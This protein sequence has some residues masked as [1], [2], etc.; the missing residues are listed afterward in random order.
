MQCGACGASSPDGKRF[1]GE[2][3]SALQMACSSCGSPIE[4]NKRFC[5]DCGTANVAVSGATVVGD[6]AS[7][8]AGG[9]ETR[10][11]DVVAQLAGSAP[12]AERRLC[13]VL[14]VDL[15]G[16]T[17][18]S[19]VRDAEDVREL[20]SSY[21]EVASTIVGRY[22]GTIEKFIGDAV[23]A[24]W[25]SPV[26][27]EEDSERAVRAALDLVDAVGELGTRTGVVGLAARAG[28]LTG[29]VAV[30]I[31]ATNEGMVA[32]DAVN[33][34]A[35]IQ[36]AAS[37]GSVWVDTATQRL[38]ADAISYVDEG[39]HALKGKVD[40][41]RLWR[42]QRVVSSVGGVQRVD[43]L[44]APLTGRGAEV[45]S[46]RELFHASIERRQPRLV[47]VS[48]PAGVGKSRLGWEF[49]KYVDGLV[50]TVWWHRGRC[51]AY[52]DG[53][54][55]WALAEVV[56]QRFGIAE[57]DSPAVA[58]DKLRH[59]LLD[60]VGD[61]GD[62]EFIGLRLGR[63]LGVKVDG[64][65]LDASLTREDLFAG[66]RRF[67][68]QL[69]GEEPVV[70]LIEDAHRAAPELLDFLDHLID[71]ARDL[72]IFVLVFARPDID[73]RRPGFGSGRNRVSITLDPLDATSMDQ[74]VDALIQG[75]APES[76]SIIV[77]RAQGIPLYAVES[78]RALIDRDIVQP[79]DGQYRLVGDIGELGVPN[80]LHALLAARLDALDPIARRVVADAAVL[81]ASFP[82][83]AVT[84]VSG[85]DPDT[86]ESVLALLLR[87]EVLEISAD[88]LSPER[89]SYRFTQEILRQV[90]YDTLS[91]R[92][93]KSRHLAVASHLRATF[94]NDGEEVIDA[95]ARH[96]LDALSEVPDDSDREELTDTAIATLVRAA[97]RSLRT[98]SPGQAVSSF[99]DAA[100]LLATRPDPGPVEAAALWLRA[101]QGAAL[102]NDIDRVVGL[103]ERAGAIYAERND[104]RGQARAKTQIGS[105]KR[106]RGQLAEGRE[107]L[108]E[109]LQVLE[110]DPDLDT[111]DALEGLATVAVFSGSDD[112]DVLTSRALELGHT[113]DVD[114]GRYA[115]LLGLRG[116]YFLDTAG[117]RRL[118][119]MYQRE[120]GRLALAYGDRTV[121]AIAYLNLCN[122]LNIDRPG[123]AIEPARQAIE[124]LSELGDRYWIA[125]VIGNMALA[126]IAVGDW[127]GADDTLFHLRHVD[128][129][130]DDPAVIMARALL[131]G[132]RGDA[133]TAAVVLERQ[134]AI[135]E[136]DDPAI[137]ASL[138]SSRA[139]AAAARGDRPDTLRH[140]LES[141]DASQ[142][143][144]IFAGDDGR[145]TWP[146][147]ARTAHE[148]EQFDV[149]VSLVEMCERLPIG[150]TA[151][152]QRA[153]ATLIRARLA[154]VGHEPDADADT[155]FEA[156][157]AQLRDDSTPYHLAHGLLD[158]AE[159]LTARGALPG[160]L[161]GELVDEARTIADA[162][163]CRPLV[164]RAAQIFG[165]H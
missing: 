90:A 70:I 24:V 128:L 59:G 74:L 34:A 85:L 30:T 71:W 125:G 79:V 130:E 60:H 163:G 23:M 116:H 101:V 131:S 164:E 104:L 127:N 54:V 7:G 91:R 17:S 36:S 95:V 28:V 84:A 40:P 12:V 43:G 123:E 159:H 6:V 137:I 133:D 142:I 110:A 80:S 118:A 134:A 67:F 18:V 113:L 155:L 48:G 75:A 126:Q 102:L 33:T 61:D 73:D 132:L 27:T 47:L 32:G 63:L 55:Y 31:G 44:E 56:R 107:I 115:N 39:D 148:L 81:G 109:A 119:A 11:V 2:C 93:R 150:E 92:D 98:G 138:A 10:S 86:V 78:I 156:A 129:V 1:C 58:A 83:E 35:R 22:G 87:R 162:L 147:A 13:S 145:W 94:S 158:H 66:W 160:E 124:I 117:Q 100:R 53:L 45:R 99:D 153:E 141:L 114:D 16:F 105:A 106:R 135:P 50:D 46:L 165:I 8:V 88:P 96:Y 65:G 5:G 149:E 89:G 144:V 49:E 121:A 72:P 15:V 77:E 64:S 146:L 57:D 4:E 139:H 152:M 20:L 111:L 97:E 122:V 14:F 151:P 9:G 103:A 3:G 38:T 140:A 19:E 25:G 37:P 68:E 69:A 136:S 112:A 21:F 161:V 82:A 76:R 51:L 52:G 154:S 157:I 143:S 41:E 120:S 62:R 26:A 42:A 108:T 29:E